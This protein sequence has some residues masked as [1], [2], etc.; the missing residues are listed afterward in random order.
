M[1]EDMIKL[2]RERIYDTMDEDEERDY[3]LPVD[4]FGRLCLSLIQITL[5]LFLAFQKPQLQSFQKYVRPRL[6]A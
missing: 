4:A 1:L 6:W 2:A 5:V 3:S